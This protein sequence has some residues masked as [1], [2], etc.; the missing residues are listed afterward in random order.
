ML[1]A[2]TFDSSF[3]RVSLYEVLFDHQAELLARWA[4]AAEASFA[5]SL[6]RVELVDRMPRFVAE[7]IQ[8]LPPGRPPPVD[9]TSDNAEEHGVQRLRLGFDIGEVVREYGLLHEVILALAAE[10]GLTPTVREA[11]VLAIEIG[12]GTRDAV[13]QYQAQRD[14]ELQRQAAAHLG[15]IAHELR[16]PLASAQMANE[17]LRRH[18][19]EGG[20]ASEALGRSLARLSGMIDG[21]LSN[22]SLTMGAAPSRKDVGLRAL[23]ADIVRDVADEAE[24]KG[25]VL[26]I[27]A[28]PLVVHVDPRLLSSAVSNLVRNALKFTK[29]D[30]TVVVRAWRH[31]AHLLLE[32]EDECGGLPPGTSEELFKPFVQKGSDRSGFGLGL[33]I[34][35]QAVESL[36]GALRVE[37]HPGRGCVFRIELH[38]AAPSRP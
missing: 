12:N 3:Y 37:D 24:A 19:P 1:D 20:R 9:Q 26:S 35:R 2:H 27:Q 11:Q 21:V 14:G 13:T 6:S 32:V 7:L 29:A 23:L 30:T 18:C 31:E 5:G 10:A 33:A 28:E 15:F 36:G 34:A 25:I 22:A 4:D 8:A 17:S 38:Q 16:N